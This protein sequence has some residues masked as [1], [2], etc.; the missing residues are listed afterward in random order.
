MALDAGAHALGLVGEM[1]SGPG[2]ID[3]TVIADIADANREEMSVLLTSQTR[4]YEI[5][6]HVARAHT[7]AVQLVDT[8][9]EGTA[10]A[11]RARFANLTIIQVIHVRGIADVDA[12]FNAALWADNLLLDSGAP[13]GAVKELGGTGRTHNWELSRK[14]V[15]RVN[16][17]VWLAGGLSPANVAEAIGQVRPFGVDICSGLRPQG[18][19]DAQLLDD[20]MYEVRNA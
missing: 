13:D 19:L 12:A 10:A 16:K 8:V 3:D 5:V 15:E 2:P 9:E 7:R 4:A 1:P 17:P 6:R 18:V 11:L 14:I 20:F